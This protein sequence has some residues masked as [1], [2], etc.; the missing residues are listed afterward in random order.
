[1]TFAGTPT[2]AINRIRPN[3]GLYAQDQWTI[4]RLTVNAGLRLDYFRSDY[5]DQN[6]PP[7]QFVPVTRSFPAQGSGQ[8]EG[9]EP[10]VRRGVRPVR[11]RQDGRQGE[12]EPLRPRR[13]HR[14][15]EHDQSDPEQQHDGAHVGRR[16]QRPHHPGR[17]AEFRAERRAPRE[18][19]S[20]FREARAHLPLRPGVVARVP[21]PALQLG[22]LGRRPA[23]ADAAH[24]GQRV[25]LPPHL[26]QLHASPTAVL[27]GAERL[28]DLLRRRPG[29]RA[30]A[31]RRRRADLR[32]ARPQ[33][34]ALAGQLDHRSDDDL[35]QQ[36][37]RAVRALERRRP[38]RQCAAAE[39]C[40]SRAA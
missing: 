13:R 10:A 36:L 14:P 15:R 40:C 22:I 27:V 20:E 38:D 33:R 34:V 16:E 17:S 37:R 31:R 21:E 30:A 6:V 7:T 4:N 32:A 11:Q 8:L 12:R 19:E 5:P 26:R 18:P 24:V 28:L 23:R 25:V 1:M 39:S 3:L 2:L 9:P 29:R 35:R